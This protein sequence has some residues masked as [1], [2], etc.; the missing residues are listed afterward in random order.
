MLGFFVAAILAYSLFL[1]L[2][3]IDKESKSTNA[4][5]AIFLFTG[6][7]LLTS[8]LFVIKTTDNYIIPIEHMIEFYKSQPAKDNS[9]VIADLQ[10]QTERGRKYAKHSIIYVPEQSNIHLKS[11]YPASTLNKLFSHRKTRF[12]EINNKKRN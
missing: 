12:H 7:T 2:Q 11:V 4:W 5:L 9:A 6:F 3:K 1:L 10:R 8:Y